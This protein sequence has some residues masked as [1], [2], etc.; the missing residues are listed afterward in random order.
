M[1][2]LM[3]ALGSQRV[4]GQCVAIRAASHERTSNIC[5]PE[6]MQN[7]HTQGQKDTSQNS[8]ER[9]FNA[10]TFYC[11]GRSDRFFIRFFCQA[12]KIKD[13][14]TCSSVQEWSK[15]VGI[16]TTK[17]KKPHNSVSSVLKKRNTI[18]GKSLMEYRR[19]LHFFIFSLFFMYL[20]L[21]KW[22]SS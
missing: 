11:V 16:K 2:D 13:E 10:K 17:Q 21:P 14:L 3:W 9:L 22:K 18:P 19:R 20:S 15:L 1:F 5:G 8:F 7:S 12:L 6:S 4:W